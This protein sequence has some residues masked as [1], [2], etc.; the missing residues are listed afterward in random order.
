ML[1]TR[2]VPEEPVFRVISGKAAKVLRGQICKGE[3]SPATPRSSV[4]SWRL[5]ADTGG[6]ECG[7]QRACRFLLIVFFPDH[8]LAHGVPGPGIQA[9]VVTYSTVVAALDP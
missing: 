6:H 5:G 8:P 3:L 2:S 4:S 9:T 1:E 7:E